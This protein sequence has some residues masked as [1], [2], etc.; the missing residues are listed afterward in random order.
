MKNPIKLQRL[1]SF[2]VAA[3]VFALAAA[4]PATAADKPRVA[5][6]EFK[7]KADQDW[8]HSWNQGGAAAAQDVFVTQLVKSGKFRVI[9]REQLDALMREKNL[10][11]SGDVS[12]ATAVRAGR[13]LGVKYI[14]TGAVTEYGQSTSEASGPGFKRIPS[15]GVKR[16]KFQS[17]MNARMIDAETG[18]IIWADEA[19]GVSSSMKVRVA[20]FGG[21][22]DDEAQFDRVLK[23]VVKE[24]VES[25]L[26][27]M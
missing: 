13:L 19:R 15:F 23:P 18:E 5:V 7:A 6:I 21:G 8:W 22:V 27:S 11:L 17:A 9:E 10:A 20:G 1:A 26:A 14:L 25:I 12:P 2:A 16:N 24:L 4:P 3:C